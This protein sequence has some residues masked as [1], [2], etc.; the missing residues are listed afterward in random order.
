MFKKMSFRAK[1]TLSLSLIFVI[2]S[3][4]ILVF[5]FEREK[6]Y[7]KQQLDNTLD[8]IAQI[9]H[10]YIEIKGLNE[11]NNFYLLDSLARIIPVPNVRIT[12]IGPRGD[13]WYDSEVPDYQNMENHLQRPEVQLSVANTFGA[14]I[15]KSS[16]TGL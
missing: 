12:V 7:K 4:L 9:C 3:A 15:R 2:F 14:N 16:T 5:Q 11:Q 1:I 13:V 8:N 6:E 10:N